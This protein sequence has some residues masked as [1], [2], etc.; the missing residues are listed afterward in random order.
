MLK[1]FKSYIGNKAFYRELFAVAM[2]IALHQLLTAL[3][4]FLDSAMI[5]AW[6]RN[7]IGS[8]EILTS[9]VM[10]SNRYFTSFQ[11]ILTMVA[12]S[13]TIFISQYLGA[14]KHN[15]LK[16]IFGLS[17]VLVGILSIFVFA[18]GAL[19]PREIISFFATTMADGE[20][21]IHYGE[22]YLFIIAFT[23]IPLAISIPMGFALRS[24]KRTMIP[25][26]ATSASVAT[27]ALLNWIFIYVLNMGIVGAAIATLISRFVELGIM[28]FYYF[29]YKPEFY[30]SWN[31][32]FSFDTRMTKTV[33]RKGTPMMFAQ[34]VTEAI[35]V[36]M[37]FAFARIEA[38]NAGNIAA[39][40]LS[41]RIV[42]IV[43]SLVG[44]M[45][46]AASILVGMRLGAGNVEEARTNARWQLG[47]ISLFSLFSTLAMIGLIP[48]VIAIYQFEAST[49]AL[50]TSVMIIHALSLPFVF[51]SSNVI[52]ITRAGGYT[53]SPI[54][55]TNVPYLFIKIPLVTLFV[56][57]NRDLFDQS[58]VLHPLMERLGFG[59]SLVIFIFL[60]DRL[61]EFI[62]AGI[63]MAIY[64]RTQW[65]DELSINEEIAI[66][67]T[68]EAI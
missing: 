17:I 18:F 67:A 51:Y 43:I 9:S 41:S 7:N 22:Q 20:A 57:I 29:K 62:R 68:Q 64:H 5:G 58:V 2:P 14:K 4:N 25:L 60:I 27:N 8:S 55:I 24:V 35:N 6:G 40:N 11:F 33:L 26:I 65:W 28:L 16:Q 39:V 15:K 52:F 13:C 48:V 63:A 66:V 44:G 1:F 54:W 12:I 50:L 21:M 42:D 56:F 53:K 36:F 45:G 32:V 30:G 19:Y 23:F 61:I 3:V 46:S 31:E 47:Y 59:T 10:I 49:S 34:V 38:G 37:F